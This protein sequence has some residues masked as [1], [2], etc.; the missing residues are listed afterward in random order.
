[1]PDP[2]EEVVAQ[3]SDIKTIHEAL[4]AAYYKSIS[5]DMV[6][7]Y[8]QLDNTGRTS[9]Q[10]AQLE[11]ALGKAT[12]ILELAKGNDNEEETSESS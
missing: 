12:A 6:E 7:A 4:N 2:V 5:E 10:T 9:P 11:T 8:R 3:T 1:M